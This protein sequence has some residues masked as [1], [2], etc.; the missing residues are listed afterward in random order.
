M[1]AVDALHHH[2]VGAAVVPVDLRHVEQV[3]S[4]RSC[5]AAARRWPP[6]AS[7]RARRGWSSRTP[8]TTSTGRSRCAL[9]GVV[10]QRAA[11][12][13]C[14]HLEVALDQRAHA[15]PQHLDHDFLA[16]AQP[17]GVHLRDRGGRERVLVEAREHLGHRPAVGALDD[18]ARLGARRTAARGPAASRA[19]RRCRR[20]A[21]RGAS[22]APGRT[23]RRSGRVPRARGAGARR[24]SRPCGARTTSRARGRTRNR[25]GRYRCVARIDLV[26]PV[27]HEHALDLQ[28][29]GDDA[30]AHGGRRAGLSRARPASAT[31]DGALRG[32]RGA[33]RGARR[34]RAAGRRPRGTPRPRRAVGRSRPS[35]ARYSATLPRERAR[36]LAAASRAGAG[37]G[38]EPG[39]PATSPNDARQFFLEV[40]PQP[41]RAARGSA[42]R[43]RRRPRC[44]RRRRAARLGARAG[45]RDQ[46]DGR[47]GE[48]RHGSPRRRRARR[49][50]VVRRRLDR[51]TRSGVPASTISACARPSQLGAQL[52]APA[53]SRRGCGS[54]GSRWRSSSMS[55]P[56]A[57]VHGDDAAAEVVVAA[58]LEAGVAHHAEQRFLVGMH[59][60]RLGEVAVAVVVARHAA[61]RATAARGTNRC[62]RAGLRPGTTGFE[63]SSTSSRPPGRSTRRI[64]ASAAGLSV[65]LRRPKPMV[66]QSKLSSANGRHSAFAS[67]EAHVAHEARVEQAVAAAREHRAR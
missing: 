50:R 14:M 24:A 27:P 33:P 8:S 48:A 61:C 66:T 10:E 44:A 3:A 54:A 29:P 36:G 59:A 52:R 60:D 2:H 49:Q 31:R 23:S 45:E 55:V 1:H 58:V 34:R 28:Q 21:G 20:A 26:E 7:G 57:A 30:Q 56:E 15:G 39:A 43:P 35:P 67:D 42:A 40:R 37:R 41:R 38:R 9:A 62:R 53:A 4:R 63:N 22:T 17:R 12:S 18:R 25:S 65:T 6:R 47:A 19:R 11:A 64:E 5:A 16:A 46:V 13:A 51:R 32:G